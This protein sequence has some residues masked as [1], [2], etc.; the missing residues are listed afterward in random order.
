MNAEFF[1]S[2][3]VNRIRLL[4]RG[5]RWLGRHTLLIL[6]MHGF[7]AVIY[8]DIL[9]VYFK[10]GP[11]WYL[12]PYGIPLTWEIIGKSVLVVLLALATCIPVCLIVD[13]G[14]RLLSKKQQEK[15]QRDKENGGCV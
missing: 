6:L 4:S 9:H 13:R 2:K 10:P 3:A 15:K 14:K 8:C 7:L 5:L 11:Y 1:F 12:G